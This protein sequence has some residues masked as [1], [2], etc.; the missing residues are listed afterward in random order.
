MYVWWAF[1]HR[2]KKFW[3]HLFFLKIFSCDMKVK[4]QSSPVE[5]EVPSLKEKND[6]F[7]KVAKCDPKK[8]LRVVDQIHYTTIQALS[9]SLSLQ[10]TNLEIKTLLFHSLDGRESIT[11][12]LIFSGKRILI[13]QSFKHVNKE[14][15][16]KPIRAFAWEWPKKTQHI[17]LFFINFFFHTT[18]SIT[19]H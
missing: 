4:V 9:L 5:L 11:K 15:R 1:V 13:F 17:Q 12:F 7:M 2:R 14:E 18:Y 10:A 19:F 16:T 8:T 6:N 3:S